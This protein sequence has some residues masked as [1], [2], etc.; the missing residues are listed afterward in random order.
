L[1]AREHFPVT[2]HAGEADDLESIESALFDGRALRLGHGVRV[3]LDIDV[4]NNPDGTQS[5]GLG[6]LAEWVR[7]REIPL[8]TSPSSNVQT[9]AI[10]PWG[11]TLAD[12]PFDLLYRL[13]FTVT[14]NTDNRLMS[15][16]TLSR[17]LGL[18]VDAFGY[19]LDDLLAFQLNAAAGAFL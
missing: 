16:T 12:H 9:A 6:R 11:T 17:E 19:G 15:S 13:G 1:L 7:N 8:E 4:R 2:V 14:V 5:A 10:E 18:L 3:A